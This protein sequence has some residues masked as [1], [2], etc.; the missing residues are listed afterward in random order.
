MKII[1]GM[2]IETDIEG[3]RQAL[4][5]FYDKPRLILLNTKIER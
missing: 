4:E 3:A 1:E 2:L 5:S